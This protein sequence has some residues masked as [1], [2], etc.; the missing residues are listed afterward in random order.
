MNPRKVKIL[1]R[2]LER[3]IQRFQIP[4][5]WNKKHPVNSLDALRLLHSVPNEQRK[6][7]TKALFKALVINSSVFGNKVYSEN[8]REATKRVV[9]L[10]APGVPF[11]YLP[12]TIS[13]QPE[14]YWGG[15]RLH[16]VETQLNWLHHVQSSV[17]QNSDDMDTSKLPPPFSQICFFP[18]ES[19][20]L[21]YPRTLLF[22]W[23]FS[24]PWSYLAWKVVT[25]RLQPLCGTKLTVINIPII[26]GGIFKQLGSGNILD[27]SPVKQRYGFKDMQDWIQHWNTLPLSEVK[28]H[29]PPI[30]LT[31]PDIFPIRSILPS[32][33]AI[34]HPETTSCLFDAAWSYNQDVSKQESIE[35][36]LV[37]EGVMPEEEA[38]RIITESKGSEKAKKVLWENGR[39]AADRVGIFGVPSFVVCECGAFDGDSAAT[40]DVGVGSL[41]RTCIC[42][43][44]IWGHDRI[45]DVL[46]E[47]LVSGKK[48]S[49]KSRI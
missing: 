34:L 1:S 4:F 13:G 15:D 23:D 10:G 22:F 21:K 41:G 5:Q 31:W 24:S 11:F 35:E 49:A 18:S 27:M 19:L 48:F 43:D 33:L 25:E 20:P 42:T 6:I 2:D 38:I 26:V 12:K 30:S 28:K 8:L 7:L 47:Q 39:W 29:R 17:L 45:M 44:V 14:T 3:T 37:D 16:F 32:R 46:L 36:I 9:E 40:N